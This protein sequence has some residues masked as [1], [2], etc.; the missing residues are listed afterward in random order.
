M[1][2]KI[3]IQTFILE[4]KNN[5]EWLY[6]FLKYNF[7]FTLPQKENYGPKGG[8]MM[9]NFRIKLIDIIPI[10]LKKTLFLCKT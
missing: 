4:I 6:F 5:D 10:S 8:I 3:L 9:F 7:S 2:F 1:Y